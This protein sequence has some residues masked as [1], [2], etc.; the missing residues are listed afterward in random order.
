MVTANPISKNF[1]DT[2]LD[3]LAEELNRDG[4]CVLRGLFNPAMIEEWRGAFDALFQSRQKMQGGLAPRE[5]A[6]YYLTLPLIRP[7]ADVEVFANPAILGVL[8]RVFAQEYAMVQLGADV[9][10]KGSTYQEVHRDYRPLFWDHVITPLYALAVNIPL[11]EV[12]EENGPFQMARGT[13]T[14]TRDDG[15]A[16]VGSGEIPMESFYMKPGDVM[17][18][19]PLALHRG[20]PNLTDTPRPMVV[21][22]YVMHWLYTPNV[23]LTFQRD[24]YESLPEQ[25]RKMLRCTVVDELQEKAETYIEFKH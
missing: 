18:R 19:T 2:D 11:V 7:F 22:G 25:V 10:L 24:Y 4:A 14:L 20:T 17:I 23:D 9:P 8:D 3:R 5:Q 1:T 21:M 15:L 6:R 16:K 12:T 13:H